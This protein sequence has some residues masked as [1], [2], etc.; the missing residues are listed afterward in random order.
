[1]I[2]TGDEGTR[3]SDQQLEAPQASAEIRLVPGPGHQLEHVIAIVERGPFVLA[4]C[5]G[6]GWETFARRSRPLARREGRDHVRLHRVAG[7]G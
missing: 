5:T 2:R 7:A 4:R 3:M 1:M 6:C